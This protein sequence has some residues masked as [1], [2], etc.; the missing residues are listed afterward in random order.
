MSSA[1]LRLGVILALLAEW[2]ALSTQSWAQ[3]PPDSNDDE[4][5]KVRL[6]FMK[7]F[8]TEFKLFGNDRPEEP[9]PALDEPLVRWTNPIRNSFSDGALFLWLDGKRPV[10]MATVSIRGN[11]G[12][13][14]ESASLSPEALRCLRRDGLF[15]NPQ[16][17]SSAEQQLKDAPVPAA[18]GAGRL[19]QMRRLSEQFSIRMEP[20]NEQPSQLRLLPQPI[21]RYEDSAVGVVDGAVFSFA[22]GTDPEA[23]LMLEAV[24]KPNTEAANWQYTLAKMSSRR[25]VARRNDEVVWSVPG[26]WIN[27]RSITDAYQERQL[28]VYPPPIK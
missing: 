10:A 18:T 14:F 17:A 9:L 5:R 22:E 4:A 8:R 20:I 16:S 15:W 25:I 26:Y 13:W 6:E 21:Y 27:P 7:E 28:T 12:V 1:S 19:V 11:G 23:L 3:E 2:T 24:R